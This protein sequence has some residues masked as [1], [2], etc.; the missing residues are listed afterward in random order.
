MA[1]VVPDTATV[2]VRQRVGAAL[3]PQATMTPAALADRHL[4]QAPSDPATSTASG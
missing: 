2:R 4:C 1:K 3:R